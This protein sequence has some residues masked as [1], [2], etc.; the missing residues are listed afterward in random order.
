MWYL[1]HQWIDSC[2]NNLAHLEIGDAEVLSA[3]VPT[4]EKSQA[5]YAV[6]GRK[7]RQH[8]P[9]HQ[10]ARGDQGT[11]NYS[12]DLQNEGNTTILTTA[13]TNETTRSHVVCIIAIRGPPLAAG[14]RSY[15]SRGQ[16]DFPG[17]WDPIGRIYTWIGATE[18]STVCTVSTA[19]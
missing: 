6:Y 5:E 4:I 14:L 1:P 11:Q 17:Q 2:E 19:R 9:T 16:S 12:R 10:Q 8:L 3:A 7:T 13:K 18:H 15:S